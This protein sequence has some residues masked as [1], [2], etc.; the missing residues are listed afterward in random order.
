MSAQTAA[1]SAEPQRSDRRTEILERA[2]GVFAR[3]G[4][5]KTTLDDIGEA[6]GLGKAALYHYFKGKDDIFATVVAR[7]G[8]R[9][10]DQLRAAAAAEADPEDQLIA[11]LKLRLAM[12]KR[13]L[14]EKAVSKETALEVL[15]LVYDAMKEVRRGEVVLVAGI[16]EAGR[17]KGV[18]KVRSTESVALA[19]LSAIRAMDPQLLMIDSPEKLTVGI[20]ELL[21]LLIRGLTR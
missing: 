19:L 15:P 20:D 13:L 9:A 2:T 11:V 14:A 21:G 18:F 10:L 6:C 5:R 12:P 4:F 8:N 17:R 1:R 16:L 7:E 3:Y